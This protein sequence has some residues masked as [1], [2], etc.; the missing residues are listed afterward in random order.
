ML[1][2]ILNASGLASLFTLTIMEVVLGIDNVIFISI[3]SGRLP[4]ESQ[5][6]ARN[7][8]LILALVIRIFLLSIIAW[9]IG[10]NKPL[11]SNIFGSGL[12]IS[13]RDII[14]LGGGLF[15]IYKSTFEIHSKLEGDEENESNTPRMS[16]SNAIVQIVLLD[17]V[18]SFDSILTAMGLVESPDKDLIIMIIAVIISLVIMLMFSKPISDFVNKHPTVKMLALSF[19]LMVGILLVAEAFHQNIPKGYI[20]FSMAFSLLVEILNM[21]MKKSKPVVLKSTP[22]Q[23]EKVLE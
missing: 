13:I 8:G 1:E 20:Y 4:K 7:I 23:E 21:K 12:D 10:F 17:I 11:V 16:L 18:F 5:S 2:P 3:L 14:L 6:K 15:L 9:I 19:L 22:K